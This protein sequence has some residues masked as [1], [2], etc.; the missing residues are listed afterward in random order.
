MKKHKSNCDIKEEGLL[1]KDDSF[2]NEV[3]SNNVDADCMKDDNG[4]A[5][6]KGES[7]SQKKYKGR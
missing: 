4:I 1:K 6:I 2:T 3:D 5:H 7:I